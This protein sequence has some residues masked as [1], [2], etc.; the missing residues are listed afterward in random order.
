MSS[1]EF[2]NVE[3]RY[4]D[5]SIVRGVSLSVAPGE[6]LVLVGPSGCGKSTCLRM[7]AGLEEISAGEIRIGGRRVNE[8]PPRDRDI[9][10][11]FQSYALYPHMTVAQN[12]GFGLKLR[13]APASEID[14]RVA[15]AARMLNL[16]G[17][18][19][20]RPRELSGGQRQRVAIGRA[21][22]RRP[23]VFLFDEPLSNL[24]AALR[25]QTRA[26]I[27]ALHKRL[28]ATMVYVTHDQVEAMTLATRIAVLNAGLLQQVGAPA[29]LFHEPANRFVA[30]F[31]GSPAM[32]FIEGAV[33]PDGAFTASGWRVPLPRGLPARPH[34]AITLGLRPQGFVPAGHDVAGT[35]EV[36]ESMGWEAYVHLKTASG[37]IVVR[38]E[39]EHAQRARMGESLEVGI[40]PGAAHWFDAQGNALRPPA[41]D[42]RVSA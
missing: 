24:D 14:A 34:E 30:G 35:V 26:E 5:Q 23:Q 1:V 4:G 12:M 29:E 40:L 13:G 2:L 17:L 9:G 3:K 36:V 31:I 22:A 18:L 8:L 32:N 20:R 25:V 19:H 37:R 15:E 6:F 27:L 28:G 16:E 33:G 11:V 39:G 41:S 21:I 10:M 38:L 42:V 7:I